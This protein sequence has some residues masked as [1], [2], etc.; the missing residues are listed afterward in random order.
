MIAELAD[1]VIVMYAGK[2]VERCAA[3]RLFAEPQHPYTIGSP[4]RFAAGSIWRRRA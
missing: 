1:D 4:A 3:E 2:V